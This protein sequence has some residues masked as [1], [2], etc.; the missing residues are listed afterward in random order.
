[1]TRKVRAGT[2]YIFRPVPLDAIDPPVGMR[3]GWLVDGDIVKVVNL[4]G[5]PKANAMGHAYIVKGGTFA[6]LV[7]CNSLVPR[8]G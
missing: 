2:S 8:K 4:R 5:C 3:E 1:M 7:H 6:G